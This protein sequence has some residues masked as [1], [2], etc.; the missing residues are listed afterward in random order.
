MKTNIKI[1]FASVLTFVLCISLI[2][3]VSAY[4]IRTALE[5]GDSITLEEKDRRIYSTCENNFV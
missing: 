4:P 3:T 2:I 5:Y 1:M